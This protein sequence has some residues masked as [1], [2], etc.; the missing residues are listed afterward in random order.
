M[1]TVAAKLCG[2]AMLM[3]VVPMVVAVVVTLSMKHSGNALV[4][5]AWALAMGR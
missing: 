3:V 4:A 2:M 5:E 1:A